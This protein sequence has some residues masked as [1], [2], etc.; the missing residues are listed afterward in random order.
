M[1]RYS[2]GL[3]QNCNRNWIWCPFN[4]ALGAF[5]DVLRSFLLSVLIYEFAW[6]TSKRI[7]WPSWNA[8]PIKLGVH[9]FVSYFTQSPM[10]DACEN[11]VVLVK[12]RGSL[13]TVFY[14]RVLLYAFCRVGFHQILHI[15]IICGF[16]LRKNQPQKSLGLNH[17]GGP[18]PHFTSTPGASA[19]RENV[20]HLTSAPWDCNAH[21]IMSQLTCP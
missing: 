21:P 3:M 16:I 18:P 10:R 19:T 7:A 6:Y 17:F 8:K 4:V 5:N 2:V 13:S 15:L 20:S 11:G 1:L 12:K 14:Q 9:T